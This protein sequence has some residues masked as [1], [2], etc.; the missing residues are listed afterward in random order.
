MSRQNLFLIIFALFYYLFFV[1]RG[2]VLYDE[3]YYTHIAQRILNG[4]VPYK[5]FFLQFTPLYFYILAFSY[6][7]FGTQIL[8]GRFLTLFICIGILFTVFKILGKFRLNP[9]KPKIIATLSI[10]SFGFPLINN[11]SILA[12]ISVLFCLIIILSYLIWFENK[13]K[14]NSIVFLSFIGLSL[15]AS[16]LTKQNLGLYFLIATNIF[17]FLTLTNLIQK[18]KSLFI[19]NAVFLFSVLIVFLYF[20]SNQV[21]LNQIFEIVNFNK[22]YLSVYSF[23][24]PALSFLLQPTGIFKLLPYYLPIIFIVFWIYAFLKK[25]KNLPVFYFSLLP[26][27]G[28][29]GTVYPTSDLLHVY[30]F[31]GIFLVSSLVFFSQKH[32]NKIWLSLMIVSIGIGFY[33]TLFREYYRY[34]P[35]YLSQN[36]EL[37][38]PKTQGIL[39][40]KPLAQSLTTLYSFIGKNTNEGDYILSYPFSPMLYFIFEKQNPSRFSIYFP[41]YLTTKQEEEVIRELKKRKVKYIITFLEYSFNTPLSLFVQNQNLIL[42]NGQFKVF[43]ISKS[44]RSEN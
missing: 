5:D 6:K 33:L 40:D 30:P 35:P 2:I 29:F 43:R 24:Y 26:L 42:E 20:F 23:S 22:R 39:I 16:F 10:I 1:N 44:L 25:A 27:V 36:Y 19:V 38:L 8:V 4:E 7:V 14:K 18:V 41:G 11:P 9:L 21:G 37:N 32:I 3:G 31:Y 12:W 15:A 13:N 28:F 17:I 34:Q